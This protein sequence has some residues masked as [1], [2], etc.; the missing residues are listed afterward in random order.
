MQTSR[1]T[2]TAATDPRNEPWPAG[3]TARILT[4]YGHT[5]DALTATVDV[6]DNDATCQSCGWTSKRSIVRNQ[7]LEE[8]SQHAR[9]CM[10][11]PR[12]DTNTAIHHSA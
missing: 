7:V 4:R 1:I 6:H 3:V 9:D 5:H 11:L 10:A 2:G 12:P 8:A